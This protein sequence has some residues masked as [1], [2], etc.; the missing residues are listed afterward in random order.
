MTSSQLANEAVVIVNS[1]E[2]SAKSNFQGRVSQKEKQETKSNNKPGH[3]DR[4]DYS[5]YECIKFLNNKECKNR[6]I[7]NNESYV[8]FQ[9]PG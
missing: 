1:A 5:Q 6:L 7:N 4:S 9:Y 3:I 2:K 8:P